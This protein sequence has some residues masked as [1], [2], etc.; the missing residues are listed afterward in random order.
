MCS[1]R[2]VDAT[3]MNNKQ[4]DMASRLRER[5]YGRS[6]RDKHH[7]RD[8]QNTLHLAPSGD[9]VPEVPDLAPAG[10]SLGS[11]LDV[12]KSAAVPAAETPDEASSVLTTDTTVPLEDSSQPRVEVRKEWPVI[13]MNMW[14]SGYHKICRR[15]DFAINA[16]VAGALGPYPEDTVIQGM[17]YPELREAAKKQLQSVSGR[18]YMR[19]NPHDWHNMFALACIL[20]DL[21]KHAEVADLD[22]G[23]P[24]FQTQCLVDLQ[25]DLRENCNLAFEPLDNF[26]E[27]RET[28]YGNGEQLSSATDPSLASGDCTGREFFKLSRGFIEERDGQNRA[29]TDQNE[30]G[31]AHGSKPKQDLLFYRPKQH[32]SGLAKQGQADH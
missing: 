27:D 5:L 13:D 26:L 16:Y 25:K 6:L 22:F 8:T 32:V 30:W 9:S 2:V 31:Y 17:E 3:F 14:E 12:Q 4:Y 7:G 28:L 20:I 24:Q 21:T 15:Y 1:G 18:V 10:A 11:A 19:I 29:N 23:D